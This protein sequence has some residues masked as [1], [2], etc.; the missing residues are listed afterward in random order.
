[1]GNGIYIETIS[2][3]RISVGYSHWIII[4]QGNGL[5][6]IRRHPITRANAD[7]L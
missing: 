3:W 1:M 4:C 7:L 6:P 5:V 2:G